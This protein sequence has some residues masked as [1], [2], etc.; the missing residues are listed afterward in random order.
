MEYRKKVKLKDNRECVL[1]NAT[2][3]DAEVVLE[4]FLRTHGQTDYL[5]SYPEENTFTIEDEKSFLKRK[6]ESAR[7]LMLVAEIDGMIIG[8]AGIDG[9]K[10][11]CKTRHRVSLGIGID[12]TFWGLGVGRAML[13][14]CIECA[15][16]AGFLQMELEVVSENRRA[17]ELYHRMGFVEYGRN[18]KAFFS[19]L[20]GWQE[21]V[22][23]R[24]ELQEI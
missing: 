6:R 17:M 3:N 12:E 20:T 14:A 9:M 15:R 11:A 19:R 24:L 13:E 23:M 16:K 22:L 7:D 2:E 5:A 18:P 4:V 1:R 8:T 10:D 21:T